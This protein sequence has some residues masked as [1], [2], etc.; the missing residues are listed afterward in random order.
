MRGDEIDGA[1]GSLLLG[2]QPSACALLWAGGL[3][4]GFVPRCHPSR[5]INRGRICPKGA[6]SR[7]VTG[8]A[9]GVRRPTARLF[10]TPFQPTKAVRENSSIQ[11]IDHTANRVFV[12]KVHIPSPICQHVLVL[13]TPGQ[14][15]PAASHVCLT[16]W[17]QE[18]AKPL[19]SL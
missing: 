2:F 5:P 13:S 1:Q 7:V 3:G 16:R 4:C 12:L 14:N 6:V 19:K 10:F 17:R 18:A 8:S 11:S 15:P 9:D